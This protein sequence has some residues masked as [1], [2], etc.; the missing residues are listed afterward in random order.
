MRK[1]TIVGAGAVGATTAF[2][3]SESGI[4]DEILIIDINFDRAYG[5]ATDIAHGIPL[6]KPVKVYSG[7][8]EDSKDSDIVIITVGVPEKTGESRLVPLKKNKEILENIV[9]EIVKNSPNA[10]I[11]VVSN[12]VDILTYV[13]YKISKLPKNQVFGLGTV[14]DSSRLRWALS[15]DFGIDGRN[16]IA[17]MIGEHGDTQVPAWSLSTI[18]GLSIDKFAE[19]IGIKLDKNYF[20][21]IH[22]EI[23]QSAFDVWE[24]KGPNC[25][26]VADSIKV[27]VEAILR[28]ESSILPVSTVLENEYGISDVCVSVPSIINERGVSKVLDLPLEDKEKEGLY[29]SANMLK[30]FIK[31][32]QI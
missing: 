26:C 22:N 18:A 5:N 20:D 1:I 9:P 28:N 21:N 14:L 11:L 29:N 32:L 10:K 7:N 27:V 13:T 23:K 2:A 16:I 3:L 31:E 15:R 25:Y 30:S 17:Y 24:K 6:I 4:C 19:V 8:Y 12:P